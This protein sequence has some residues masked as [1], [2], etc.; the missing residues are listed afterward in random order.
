MIG[1][2]SAVQIHRYSKV[3]ENKFSMCNWRD[4]SWEAI[5]SFEYVEIVRELKKLKMANDH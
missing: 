1:E 2:F 3:L 4:T 5:E